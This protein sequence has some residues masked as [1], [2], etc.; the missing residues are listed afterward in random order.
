VTT[1]PPNRRQ[2]GT[3]DAAAKRIAMAQGV[4]ALPTFHL[5]R[6]A[7]R[8]GVFVGGKPQALRK[9]LSEQLS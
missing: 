8:V 7:E 1:H 9:F 6:K 5:F 4:K 2:T 3:S